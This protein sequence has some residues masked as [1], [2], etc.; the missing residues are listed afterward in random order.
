MQRQMCIRDRLKGVIS[1]IILAGMNV[2]LTLIVFAVVPVMVVCCTRFNHMAVSYTHLDGYKR[3][4][5]G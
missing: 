1:F 4:A 2:W 5:I 3:Q